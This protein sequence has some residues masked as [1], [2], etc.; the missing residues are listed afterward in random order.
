MPERAKVNSVEAIDRFRAQLVVYIEKAGTALDEISEEVLR[1]KSWLEHDRRAHWRRETV[2]RRRV[3][4]QCQQELFSARLSRFSEG[5]QLQQMAVQRARRALQEADDR[6]QAVRRWMQ[7][8]DSRVQPLAR[9]VEKLRHVLTQDMREAATRLTQTVKI[10]E[11]YTESAPRRAV[12]PTTDP[13][14]VEEEPKSVEEEPKSV[15]EEPTPV[16]GK[17]S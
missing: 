17:P 3:L 14:S 4:E 11:A 13:K 10:L 2:K 5:T 9:E 8:Y 15:E 12:P 6:I 1:T 7:Q 16:K